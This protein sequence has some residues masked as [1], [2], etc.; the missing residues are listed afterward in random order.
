MIHLVRGIDDTID[1]AVGL[2]RFLGV[3]GEQIFRGDIEDMFLRSDLV[4]EPE[5]S[6][7]GNV[8]ILIAGGARPLDRLSAQHRFLITEKIPIGV[9]LGAVAFQGFLLFNQTQN[10]SSGICVPQST[11]LDQ[12]IVHG[13]RVH[14]DAAIETGIDYGPGLIETVS[15]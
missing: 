9:N 4:A 14:T 10:G 1:A 7:S 11:M 12:V 2:T 15:K 6:T 13:A 3:V 8:E 5:F